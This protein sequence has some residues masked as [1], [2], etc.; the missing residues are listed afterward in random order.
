MAFEGYLDVMELQEC[1][2]LSFSRLSS[3]F[4]VFMYPPGEQWRT[5]VEVVEMRL[6]KEKFDEQSLANLLWALSMSQV[7]DSCTSTTGRRRRVITTSEKRV[8]VKL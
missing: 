4:A 7:T 2:P 1:T 5:F 6:Q 8:L 3:A